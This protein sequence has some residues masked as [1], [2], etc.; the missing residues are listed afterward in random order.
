MKV[1]VDLDQKAVD[2]LL[3]QELYLWCRYA[4]SPMPM[5]NTLLNNICKSFNNYIM[6]VRDK[7]IIIYLGT[8][9]RLLMQR[10]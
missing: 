8:I 2:W 9:R 6:E 3:R 5:F 1:L 4:F 7:I 10:F